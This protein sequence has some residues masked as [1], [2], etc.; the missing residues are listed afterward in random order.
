MALLFESV[1]APGC[2]SGHWT[3]APSSLREIVSSTPSKSDL[4]MTVGVAG[5]KHRCPFG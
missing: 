4:G 1:L 2:E 5:M 3:R